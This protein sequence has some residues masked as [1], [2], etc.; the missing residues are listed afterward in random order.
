MQRPGEA[1]TLVE[2]VQ[3]V[4][5][6]SGGSILSASL[7]LRW[8]RL[9]FSDTGPLVQ[10]YVERVVTPIRELAHH[11]TIGIAFRRLCPEGAQQRGAHSAGG[12][13]AFR[14]RRLL[15]DRPLRKAAL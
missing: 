10:S 6:V 15:Q 8:T 13:G 14:A 11:F 7:A 3:R 2:T 5:S 9:D 4:S 1:R 12:E